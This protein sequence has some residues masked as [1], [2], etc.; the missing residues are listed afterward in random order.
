MKIGTLRISFLGSYFY[1]ALDFSSGCRQLII[2]D[3]SGATIS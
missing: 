3:K 1:L 2:P